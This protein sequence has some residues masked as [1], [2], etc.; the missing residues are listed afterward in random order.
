M[1][2]DISSGPVGPTLKENSKI[3]RSTVEAFTN[4]RTGE[5]TME[6][7]CRTRCMGVESLHGQM[8]E[9]TRESI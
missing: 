9:S 8:G 7:G 1:D 4:G 2:E 6:N 5:C 3:M